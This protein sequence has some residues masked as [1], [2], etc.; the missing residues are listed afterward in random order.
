M[1]WKFYVISR[2]EGE[3]NS[4]GTHLKREREREV[5]K[6]KMK[7]NGRKLQSCNEMVQFLREDKNE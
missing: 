7:P 1:T 2:G 5:R 4:V 3:V 6:E